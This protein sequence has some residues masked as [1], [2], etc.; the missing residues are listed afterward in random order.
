MSFEIT[1][2]SLAEDM[3][4]ESR[5]LTGT[6]PPPEVAEGIRNRVI[7]FLAWRFHDPHAYAAFD[8]VAHYRNEAKTEAAA[9]WVNDPTEPI[10]VLRNVLDDIHPEKDDPDLMFKVR[11]MSVIT[12]RWMEELGK[13]WMHQA[14]GGH[15]EVEDGTTHKVDYVPIGVRVND[16]RPQADQPILDPNDA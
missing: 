8:V 15:D 11:L 7:A 13:M 2:E 12:V 16:E 5:E 3:I 4:A 6:E 1:W 10:E 14:G 9:D